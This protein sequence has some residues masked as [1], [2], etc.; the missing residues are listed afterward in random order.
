MELACR[1]AF[2]ALSR[3]AVETVANF[4]SISVLSGAW[5]CDA[6]CTI[7]TQ[8]MPDLAQETVLDIVAQRLHSH[9]VSEQFTPMDSAVEVL[10]V[11]D[12][13]DA[14]RQQKH[15]LKDQK[16]R[17]VFAQEYQTKRTHHGGTACGSASLGRRFGARPAP[18]SDLFGVPAPACRHGGAPHVGGVAPGPHLCGGCLGCRVCAVH[19]WQYVGP[20]RVVWAVV[21]RDGAD[22]RAA[23]G[24]CPDTQ[25]ARRAEIAVCMWAAEA[26]AGAVVVVSWPRCVGRRCGA[27]VGI[28]GHAARARAACPLP[29]YERPCGRVR[30]AQAAH[31]GTPRRLLVWRL[32]A[33]GPPGVQPVAGPGRASMW[34]SRRTCR[35]A[36][37]APGA[38]PRRGGAH[39]RVSARRAADYVPGGGRFCGAGR[40][41]RSCARRRSVEGP[42]PAPPRFDPWPA[43]GAARCQVRGGVAV[44]RLLECDALGLVNLTLT[45]IHRCLR[46]GDRCLFRQG[47]Q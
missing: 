24:P 27:A 13:R 17:S 18:C 46:R 44:I 39:L 15:A 25:C 16:G 5:I 7:I 34:C 23:V 22:W 37:C 45:C 30:A 20:P 47:I 43:R 41:R 3:S 9:S 26:T 35:P 32:V 38:G 14:H 29:E 4:A 31:A 33:R 40:G 42:P 1:C 19:R 11:D 36:H 10:E 8:R 2:W 21:W 6:L 12:Q 28:G